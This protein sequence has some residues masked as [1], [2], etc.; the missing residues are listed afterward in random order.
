MT[1][2]F[3]GFMLG[4]PNLWS[5]VTKGRGAKLN[6][7]PLVCPN[8]QILKATGYD[9]RAVVLDAVVSSLLILK[10]YPRV[11]KRVKTFAPSLLVSL[12]LAI[13]FY[14][15]QKEAPV[16]ADIQSFPTPKRTSTIIETIKVKTAPVFQRP[17]EGA[18]SQGYWEGHH[19]ID[20]PNA[21]GAPIR[22][23]T[24]GLVTFAGWDTFGYGYTVVIVHSDG[25]AS[26]YAHLEKI[27]VQTGTS[28]QNETILGYV[29]A[30]GIATGTHL[31]LELYW[32]GNTVNP[33]NFLPNLY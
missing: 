24:P 22:P 12:V 23:V 30:T 8:P 5:L 17:L 20:I 3:R 6:N 32:N 21:W 11:V 15:A 16:S 27:T 18:L 1:P 13:L 33:I 9:A 2:R 19:G 7:L 26:R 28:V 29:G 25:F 4:I 10:V 31:H 14:F